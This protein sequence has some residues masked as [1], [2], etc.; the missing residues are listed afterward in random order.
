MAGESQIRRSF[1][2]LVRKMLH[3]PSQPAVVLLNTFPYMR[4]KKM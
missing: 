4:N 3:L 2:R 1:E